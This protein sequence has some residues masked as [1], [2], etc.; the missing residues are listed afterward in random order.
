MSKA[1]RFMV[2]SAIT[3]AQMLRRFEAD[4]AQAEREGFFPVEQSW[5]GPTLTVTY[6]RL[7]ESAPV[8]Q[9]GTAPTMPAS[10][11]IGSRLRRRLGLGL[12]S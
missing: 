12:G 6:R 3:E 11:G 5:D 1:T 8:G 2:Y 7:G 4:A 9:T 10:F